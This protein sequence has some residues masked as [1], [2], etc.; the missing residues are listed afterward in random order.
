[1]DKKTAAAAAA[2]AAAADPPEAGTQPPAQAHAHLHGEARGVV[3][4]SKDAGTW[5][6]DVKVIRLLGIVGA[7]AAGQQGF[8]HCDLERG[9]EREGV[10]CG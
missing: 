8:E 10:R 1:M 9:E 4:A 2:A 6:G 5:H 3:R 7:M